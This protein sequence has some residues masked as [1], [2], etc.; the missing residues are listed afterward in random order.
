MPSPAM[1]AAPTVSMS[2]GQPPPQQLLAPPFYPPPGVMTFGNTNFPYAAG[3]TL[4]PMYPNPQV[5]PHCS[6]LCHS[7]DTLHT[8]L[9]PSILTTQFRSIGSLPLCLCPFTLP[10]RRRPRCMEESPTM[11]PCSSK[12]S[13]SPLPPAV[14]P[15]P[16]LSNPLLQRSRSL[17]RSKV[18]SADHASP[19]ALGKSPLPAVILKIT[20]TLKAYFPKWHWGRGWG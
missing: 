7:I 4:P 11:T 1:Y 10:C 18:L 6:F 19:P 3:A 2:P 9:S 13:P 16:L 15:S 14:P 5:G 20:T 12:P 8:M 17:C